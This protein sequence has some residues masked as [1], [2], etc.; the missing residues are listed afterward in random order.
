VSCAALGL[1]HRWG[2]AGKVDVAA[3]RTAFEDGCKLGDGGACRELADMFRR[4]VGVV[5]DSGRASSL[6]EQACTLGEALAC[7]QLGRLA[8]K[9]KEAHASA[10]RRRRAARLDA[11]ACSEGSALACERAA[12][13][14]LEGRGGAEKS[15]R[16]ASQLFRR[17]A[18]LH[19]RACLR[20]DGRACDRLA[21]LHGHGSG[22][23]RSAKQERRLREKA[24]GLGNGK[25]CHT[26]RWSV[27]GEDRDLSDDEKERIRTYGERACTL[28]HSEA[29]ANLADDHRASPKALE[30]HSRACE[31]GRA[32]SCVWIAKLRLRGGPSGAKDLEKAAEAY[33]AACDL[34]FDHACHKAGDMFREGR[35]VVHDL[36]RARRVLRAGVFCPEERGL[37][38]LARDPGEV[39]SG[40]LGLPRRLDPH[41]TSRVLG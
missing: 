8:E 13:R 5:P 21:D 20:G 14:H 33:A 16:K 30:Y 6:W 35:G 2:G 39:R 10:A 37:R 18:K 41:V 25:A 15:R 3:A 1:L 23:R 22:V 34:G 28:G 29:C 31:L 9:R 32:Q 27:V 40:S 24:C 17:A 4:G 38:Q 26:L 11:R 19:R 7:D 36:E 12:D